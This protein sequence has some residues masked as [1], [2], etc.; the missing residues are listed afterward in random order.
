MKHLRQYFFVA[1]FLLFAASCRADT[2]GQSQPFFISPQFDIRS[3]TQVSAVLAAISNRAYFYVE[4]SYWTGVS[5]DVRNQTLDEIASLGKEFDQRIYPIET[6]FFGS[7]P[8][9]GIDGDPKITILLS[10]LAENAG[11]YFDTANEYKMG[12]VPNSNEREMVYLN[13]AALSDQGKIRAFLAHEFQHL[14]SFNQKEKLRNVADDTWLNELRS[15]Y[16]ITLLGYNDSFPSSNLGNRLRSF[17]G[18]PSDSLTEWK[19]IPADYGQIDLFGEYLAEHWSPKVIADTLDSSSIGIASINDALKQ[20]GFSDSFLD[21][22]SQW[23]AANILNDA[24]VNPRFGYVRDGLK[25]F[26]IAPTKTF[27]NL[28]DNVT[29]VLSDIIKDWQGKWYEVSQF[30]NGGKNTL[31]INFSSPSL[32]SFNVYYLILKTDGSQTLSLFTP[33]V[34]SSGLYISGIGADVKKVLLMPVKKDKISGFTADETAVPLVLS[35]D[36]AESAPQEAVIAPALIPTPAPPAA[37]IQ[38][39]LV[40]IPDGSLIRAEGDYK[41]YVVNDHWRRHITSSQIFN[42]YPQFGFDKV[43]IISPSILVQYQESDL[44][45]YQL[46]QKVYDVDETGLKHWLNMSAE[47]FSASGRDWS[48]IFV[49]NLRELNFYSVGSTIIR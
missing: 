38:F 45:R 3:R 24:S 16:A 8:N 22:F 10:P 33:T 28:S 29:L 15:E 1:I 44:I 31:E 43:K 4:S 40:G 12:Q 14:I 41:V 9:P 11:G 23:T 30:A 36:R 6:Q 34:S 19:N 46:G 17:V 49:V 35:V 32:V 7:E 26:H 39:P 25:T 2:L 47:Q 20:N 13:I 5:S 48:S 37:A 27:S 21:I 18:N 42:F